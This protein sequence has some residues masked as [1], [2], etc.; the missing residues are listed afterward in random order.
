MALYDGFFD[1]VYNGDNGEY[2]RE[3]DAGAFDDYF[4]Q[5]IGSGVCV[6]DNPDS[7]LVRMEGGAAVVS[8]GYLFIEG[9]WL[10]NDADY[11]VSLPVSRTCAVVVHLNRTERIMEVYAQEQAQSYSDSLVLALIDTV[12][13]NV[14]DTRYNTDICGV[15]DTAG[16]LSNKIA[17]AINYIDGEIEGKLAAVEA[18]VNAKAS[19]LDTKIAEARQLAERIAPPPVGAIK[20]SA[21]DNA[22]DDWLLCDGSFISETDYPELVAV[23]GR[24][25]PGKSEFYEMLKAA[26][27]GRLSNIVVFGGYV[28]AYLTG[29]AVLVRFSTSGAK[30]EITVSGVESL[31]DVAG[32]DTVLSITEGSM[33]LVQWGDTAESV[34]VLECASFSASMSSAAVK[35]LDAAGKL[36]GISGLRDMERVVPKVTSIQ[37]RR[38]LALGLTMTPSS[39]NTAYT[40]YLYYASWQA[41]SFAAAQIGRFTV[42]TFRRQ[43]G[44]LVE[45]MYIEHIRCTETNFAFDPKNGDDLLYCSGYFDYATVPTNLDGEFHNAEFVVASGVKSFSQKIYGD[46]EN[47]STDSARYE[48]FK[49]TA[50]FYADEA[51]KRFIKASDIEK[52]ILP[53]GANGEVMLRAAVSDG[54]LMIDYAGYSPRYAVNFRRVGPTLPAR[55][56]LFRNSV[57]YAVIQGLWFVFV[58]TGILFAKSLSEGAWG[59]LDMTDT[60]GTVVLSG[61][62][63]YLENTLYLSGIGMDGI[64]RIARL[65][66]PNPYDYTDSGAW[67]PTLSQGGIPAYIKAREGD[68]R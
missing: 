65:S 19:E 14:E 40:T 64:P 6:H 63:E 9:Y 22:G 10:K 57:V 8:P 11:P 42:N 25:S 41:G 67:L 58:G 39:D 3:Y 29:R 36:T 31:R 53:V 48:Y 32:V 34:V 15:I 20:F 68:A 33:Y 61:S 62:I 54:R 5:I 28:W 16:S 56:K 12:A 45:Q 51:Y 49:T 2:D 35:R 27:T 50:E 59:Y 26:D 23:L 55:A 18:S 7:L 52:N 17:Y 43:Q 47:T 4:G 13:Q 38:Y 1:A 66:L 24:R 37:G 44:I 60:L 21:A 46:Y 30:K